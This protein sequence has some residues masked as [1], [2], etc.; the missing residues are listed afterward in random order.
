MVNSI[1]LWRS[2]YSVL[3]A[4]NLLKLSGFIRIYRCHG[5]KRMNTLF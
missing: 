1:D 2:S 4:H 3:G 5:F